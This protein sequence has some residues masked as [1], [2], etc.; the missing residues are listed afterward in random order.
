MTCIIQFEN[1]SI[2]KQSQ[3]TM[4]SRKFILKYYLNFRKFVN[5]YILIMIIFSRICYNIYKYTVVDK[6]KWTG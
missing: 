3:H 2:V 5:P 1:G 4:N 6:I